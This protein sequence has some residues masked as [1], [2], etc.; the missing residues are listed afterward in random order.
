MR[1][2]PAVGFIVLMI[3]V[4]THVSALAQSREGDNVA[5]L[6]LGLGYPGLYG[7]SS[8]PPLFLSFDHAFRDRITGG[9]IVSFSTSSYSDGPYK[10]SYTYIF[11]GVRGAYHFAD[12]IKDLKNTDLYGGVTL[13]YNIVSN[14]FSG[15]TL[16]GYNYSAGGSYFQFGIFVGGRYFFSPRW[17]ATAELGYDIGYFKIGISYKP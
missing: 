2:I 1:R 6:G 3:G 5:T 4:A 13:G 7:A 11:L 16:N 14:S 8:M 12:E 9:G 10:W 15:P 17:A